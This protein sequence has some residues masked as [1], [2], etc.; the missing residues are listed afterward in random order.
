MQVRILLTLDEE[1]LESTLTGRERGSGL[2][3]PLATLQ[4]AL[5]AEEAAPSV[6]KTIEGL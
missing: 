4:R 3:A 2:S 1:A 5:L 6:S